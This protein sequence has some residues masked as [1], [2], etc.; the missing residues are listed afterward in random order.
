MS[1]I[2][3]LIENGHMHYGEN[4]V[5]ETLDKWTDMKIK[6]KHLKLHMIGRLQ[7]NK[8]KFA[9]KSLIISIH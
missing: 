3:P 9:L 1:N 2:L 8:V 4:K 7:T 5:Q 6:I